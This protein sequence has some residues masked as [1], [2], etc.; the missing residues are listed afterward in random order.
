MKRRLTATIAG[1]VLPLALVLAAAPLDAQVQQQATSPIDDLLKRAGD[2]FNDLNYS[3]ADSL[4]R[5]VLAIGPRITTPQRTRALL[6]IAAASYPEEVAAQ[7]RAVAMT[8]LKQIVRTNLNVRIPQELTWAGLDS[9]LDEA[10][11]TTFGI[12]VSGD[13][14][15][16]VVGTTGT[17]RLR[18]R[19]SRPGSYQLTIMPVDGAS[20]TVVDSAPASTAGEFQFVAMRNE[21]PIFSTGN[22]AVIVTGIDQVSHDTVTVRYNARVDAPPLDF[23]TIPTRMDSS[24]LLSIRSGKFGT[25]SIFPA[26]LVGGMTFALANVVRG[27]GDIAEKVGADSKGVAIAGALAISTIVAGFLDRGRPIPANIAA[28]KAYGEAW[29]KGVDQ[30]RLENRRRVTDYRTT[31]RFDLEV[32]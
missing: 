1:V 29:Q 31:I 16:V 4:A 11:R 23:V 3:R 19:A 28:N 26:I 9:L 17:A 18:V 6:V 5:Q 21:R 2:A 12:E 25:K 30:L 13:S 15:Q 8:T 14:E 7:R 20:A 27:E 10:K 32:R 24:K 22:Y